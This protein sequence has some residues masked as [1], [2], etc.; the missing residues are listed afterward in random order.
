[1]KEIK[2]NFIKYVSLN[3]ISMIALSCY[4]LGDTYF[5]AKALGSE[6]LAALNFSISIYSIING[7]GLMIGIGG[8]TDYSLSYQK[9]EESWKLIQFTFTALVY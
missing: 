3:V 7:I 2:K 8:G 9:K 5:V 4:I 1:M 6:G